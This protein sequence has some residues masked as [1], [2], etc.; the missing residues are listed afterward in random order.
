[1]RPWSDFNQFED[2]DEL[3][4][5]TMG[6]GD[7]RATQLTTA[8]TKLVYKWFNDGD[9]FDNVNSSMDGWCNDLSSYA[10]WIDTYTEY[11]LI[12]QKIVDC[13]TEDQYTEILFEL[14]QEAL[15]LEVLK[16]LDA[17]PKID[18]IYT[19]KGRFQFV[20]HLYDE[21]YE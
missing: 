3:Y 8:V 5:P 12:L 10:N 6:E 17:L 21:E 18:S 2:A 7:T 1:M 20:D 16:D 4:L 19:C 15:D 11:G 14:C 9:V 13:F